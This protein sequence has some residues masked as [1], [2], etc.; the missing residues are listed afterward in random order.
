M[1]TEKKSIQKLIN[2]QTKD[3]P[4]QIKLDANEG[5][6]YLFPNGFDMSSV[7]LNLYPDDQ[8]NL[9]RSRLSHYLGV[10]SKMIV[11]GNGSSE[12]IELL[13]KTYVDPNEVILSIEPT[14]S[15][16][17]IYSEIYGASYR[18][19]P[20]RSDFSIDINLVIEESQKY[21]PKIIFLCS[22]NNP[23]GYQ[24]KRDDIIRIIQSTNALI[25]VD[26]AYIEFANR[27]ESV[28]QDIGKYPNLVILRTFSK[29][30]GLAAIRLG[31]LIGPESII[32]S[33]SKV[34]SPYHLNALTQMVG[35]EALLKINHMESWV[36]SIMSSREQMK[37][38]L[39]SLVLKTYEAFGNF[40]WIKDD[41]TLGALLEKQGILIRSYQKELSGYYRITIG[42]PD[43]NQK[44]I[45]AIKEI[46]RG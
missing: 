35:S 42:T 32:Q 44:L 19:V 36:S 43:E 10:P 4:Y 2:Y 39:K 14:F 6:N 7:E 11:E 3:V 33:I 21:Q 29:A 16:Y 24:M 23:T 38:E 28:L 8:A 34:K 45:Q 27:S 26:E 25:V 15:M 17:R 22:P 41:Q 40:I 37:V 12:L 46:K 20:A 13:I 18:G 31:Y 1:I 9:L 5:K 30:F